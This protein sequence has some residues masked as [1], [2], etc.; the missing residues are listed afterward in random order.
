MAAQEAEDAAPD[1]HRQQQVRQ[2]RRDGKA[3]RNRHSAGGL[4]GQ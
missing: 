3:R 1:R 2:A 4:D